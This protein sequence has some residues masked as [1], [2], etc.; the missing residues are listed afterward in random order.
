[1]IKFFTFFFNHLNHE[2][3]MMKQL[4]K[5]NGVLSIPWKLGKSIS[6]ITLSLFIVALMSSMAY[7]KEIKGK[8]TDETGSGL[9]GVTVTEKGTTNGGITDVNGQF[10]VNV[11]GDAAVL[12]FSFVGYAGIEEVVGSR[13]IIN[14]TLTPDVSSLN[15][16]VVV[17]Y[18][19]QK[20]ET[21]TGSV[22]SVKGSELVKSPVVNLSNSIAG[23]MAGVV[24]VN[25]SG[26]PGADGSA[27]RIRG[28]N[29]LNNGDALI[30]VDGIPNRAGGLDRICQVSQRCC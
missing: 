12:V 11:K 7:A 22:A 27:I 3:M 18:G 13:S 5:K 14:V 26:E 4:L 29:T 10:S 2:S 9:P 21:I 1:L 8:V 19:T 28:S 16:V 24:A 20:K 17:G 15:E 25:R 23:R 30:V 6:Q